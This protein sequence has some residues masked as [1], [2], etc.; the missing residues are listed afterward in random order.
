MSDTIDEGA[1]P[2]GGVELLPLLSDVPM[3][4]RTRAGA[5]AKPRKYPFEQMALGQMFFIAGKTR[6]TLSTYFSTVGKKLGMKFSSRMVYMCNDNGVL[7]LCEAST[8][9]AVRGLGVWRVE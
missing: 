1:L 3:P 5:A 8:P 6:N 2:Q 4:K 9:G 7:R